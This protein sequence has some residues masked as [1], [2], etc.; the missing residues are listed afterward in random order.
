MAIPPRTYRASDSN[1]SPHPL[2]VRMVQGSLAPDADDSN[3]P[4]EIEST[5]TD[6]HVRVEVRA[7]ASLL[8]KLV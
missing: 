5:T 2:D 6:L 1:N 8:A 4:I 3:A 7:P